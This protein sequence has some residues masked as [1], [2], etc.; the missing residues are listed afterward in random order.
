MINI[1][2]QLLKMLILRKIRIN[3]K[4]EEDVSVHI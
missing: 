2:K 3:Q 4:G 1:D